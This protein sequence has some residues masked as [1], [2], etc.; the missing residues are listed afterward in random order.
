V[1][2]IVLE[3]GQVNPKGQLRGDVTPWGQNAEEGQANL[4]AGVGQK[5]PAGHKSRNSLYEVDPSAQYVPELQGS[6]YVVFN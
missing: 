5:K 3:E 1:S 4:L 2:L 6:Q